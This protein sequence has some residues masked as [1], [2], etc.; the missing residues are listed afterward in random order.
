MVNFLK[1]YQT[2][3]K[4]IFVQ[5]KDLLRIKE[6]N[7]KFPESIDKKISIDKIK[8]E[9][10]IEFT[11]ENEISFLNSLEWIMD[12]ETISVMTIDELNDEIKKLNSSL[13]LI[14]E[15]Y[16]RTKNYDLVK[17]YG[18][19]DYKLKT[20]QKY[21]YNKLKKEKQKIKKTIN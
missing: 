5:L 2:K 14:R 10:Y 12:Y 20:L 4:K 21:T 6:E 1:I 7:I 13:A 19:V 9:D 3:N 15:K 11:C 17:L 16:L 18:D 8:L